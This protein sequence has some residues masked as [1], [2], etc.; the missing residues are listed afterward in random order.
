MFELDHVIVRVADLDEA[1]E[2]FDAKYGL[3]SVFGGRHAGIGTANRIV[4]LGRD[5]LE[6]LAVVDPDEHAQSGLSLPDPEALVGWMV[7][8]DDIEGVAARLGLTVRSLSRT[9]EDGVRLEWKLAGLELLRREPA[10]PVPV[11]SSPHQDP[12]PT[13]M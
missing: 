8:T 13:R 10:L 2:R 12:H 6:L 3:G 11:A 4:P 1:G 9:R 5:Y 7:R